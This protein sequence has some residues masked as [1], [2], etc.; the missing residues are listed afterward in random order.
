VAEPT[1]NA[2]EI[3]L[4]DFFTK[5]LSSIGNIT[6]QQIAELLKKGNQTIAVAE[7]LTGGL[8]SARLSSISGS[9]AYFIGGIV[10]YQTRIKV[11]EVGV[12]AAVISQNGVVSKETAIAMA[13]GIRKKFRAEIG[14][15][16]TG[17]AGPI[18]QPPAPVGR[19]YIALSAENGTEWKEFNLQGTREEIREKASQAALG[20]L[21]LHL[22]GN[23]ILG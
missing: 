14:I 13:D 16:A 21:W 22:G 9:S 15:G 2:T 18:A 7:S 4:E 23:E 1:I 20:M 19:I 10:C 3:K 6:D 11:T 8:I 17:A 12:P 5:I